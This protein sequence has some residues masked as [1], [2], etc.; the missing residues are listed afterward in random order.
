MS[1]TQEPPTDCTL[2]AVEL[3]EA[4]KH[5]DDEK[6]RVLKEEL[7]AAMFELLFKAAHA[8]KNR[9]IGRRMEICP[10]VNL[11]APFP[12][13][14]IALVS[15]AWLKILERLLEGGHYT[16]QKGPFENWAMTVAGNC[17]KDQA[18]MLTAKKRTPDQEMVP[19]DDVEETRL[20]SE[21]AALKV[22]EELLYIGDSIEA[23]E[24][25]LTASKRRIYESWSEE[26][27]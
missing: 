13:D 25:E 16:L 2:M 26:Y 3:M 22:R 27:P 10:E 1:S 4:L 6:V 15:E 20:G 5:N 23:G 24:L 19:I 21:D 9:W 18:R 8:S 12:S 14:I 11:E 7:G 17:W